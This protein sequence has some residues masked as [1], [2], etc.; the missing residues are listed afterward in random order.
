M[1]PDQEAACDTAGY[2]TGPLECTV[3]AFAATP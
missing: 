2:F 1:L 3:V